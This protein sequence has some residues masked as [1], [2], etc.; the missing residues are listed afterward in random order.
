M[1]A[2]AILVLG[3][4]MLLRIPQGVRRSVAGSAAL[5]TP[6]HDEP[7]ERATDGL[8]IKPRAGS[9]DLAEGPMHPHPIT[10]AHER[11][12]RENALVGAL[13]LAVDL[14]DPVQ[15]RDLV[16]QYRAEFPEDDNRL[17]GGYA[18]IADCLEHL[19]AATR[20]RAQHFWQTEIRSQTRRYVRR[21]CLER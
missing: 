21:Y 10:K 16:A 15:L 18:L 7:L 5:D 17:Q 12:F 9:T 6:R 11:I 8:P 19:D 13:N 14:A 1:T 4:L 2:T 3:G 20:E